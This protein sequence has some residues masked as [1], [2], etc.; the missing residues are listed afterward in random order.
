MD[1]ITVSFNELAQNDSAPLPKIVNVTN[2]G[3]VNEAPLLFTGF[4]ITLKNGSTS[5]HV[6]FNL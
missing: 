2:G 4:L 5:F 6:M 1:F 3:I